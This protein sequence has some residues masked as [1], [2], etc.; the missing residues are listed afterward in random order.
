MKTVPIS[1]EIRTYQP[2]IVYNNCRYYERE[3]IELVPEGTDVQK[4]D[5]VC[6]LDAS[7]LQEKLDEQTIE[8]TKARARVAVA[9]LNEKLQEAENARLL[10]VSR[11]KA[12]RAV[13]ELEAYREAESRNRLQQLS[14]DVSIKQE[15]TRQAQT[16]LQHQR[17]LTSL[18]VG[19]LSEL[20]RTA[21]HFGS[22]RRTESLARGE[23]ALQSQ[24][25]HPRTLIKMEADAVNLTD[26][27]RRTALQNE[28]FSAKAAITT[29]EMRKWEAGAMTYVDYLTRSIAA[30][31]MRAPKAGKV[32]YA[33]R[34]DERRFIEVGAKV[35]YTQ[36]IIRITDRSRLV[37]SGKVDHAQ[38]FS[39]REGDLTEIVP[40]K[41]GQQTYQGR[42]SWVAPIPTRSE[43]YKPASLHHKIQVVLTDDPERLKD[44][45]ISTNV[46][47]SVI[48]DDRPDVIQAPARAI[49]EIN[50]DFVAI[51]STRHGCV[52]RR[53]ELGAVN[54]TRVEILNGLQPGDHVV[55]DQRHE[56][57][58]LAATLPVEPE[59]NVPSTSRSNDGRIGYRPEFMAEF[60][61]VK[62]IQ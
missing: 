36:D 62:E 15:R 55:I 25:S 38:V 31:T 34:P 43:W 39:L 4:G 17:M 9:R 42:L 41:A 21:A 2:A 51:V 37:V 18:G 10:A 11:R 23:L 32:V 1:G 50:R 61:S 3:I 13:A 28:L 35:H 12:T 54:E 53:V 14:A 6:V 27:V 45:V 52:A 57:R 46:K 8:L 44:L 30:C 58:R 24:F 59:Y 33:H 47:G 48:V 29:L 26:D 19:R 60:R 5:V 22:L 49:T 20:Q 16:D 56:L 40:A 7:E